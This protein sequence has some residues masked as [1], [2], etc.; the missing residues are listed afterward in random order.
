MKFLKTFWD[1]NKKTLTKTTNANALH[2][3]FMIFYYKEYETQIENPASY[4]GQDHLNHT[5]N[6]N[7]VIF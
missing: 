3:T 1:Q 2:Y 5:K 6:S 4:F 7:L